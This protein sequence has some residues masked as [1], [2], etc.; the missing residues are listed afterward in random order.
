[1]IKNIFKKLL[2]FL[3]KIVVSIK[4]NSMLKRNKNQEAIFL[5]GSPLHGNIGD[6]AISIAERKLL[7]QIKNKQVLEIPGE[8]YRLCQHKIKQKVIKK[9]TILISG[10][11][12]LGSLWL[13]EENMVRSVIQTFPNN[14]IIILPQTMYFA[15]NEAGKKELAVSKQIYESHSNLWLFVRENNSYEFCK[16]NMPHL[17]HLYCVPDMVTYLDEQYPKMQREGILCC[18]RTDKEKNISEEQTKQLLSQLAKFKQPIK[19]TTTVLSKRINLKKRKLI[20]EEKLTEFRKSKMVVTDRLHAMLFAAITATPCIA[21]NNLSG[22]VQGVY[23][24]LTVLPYI[25]LFTSQNEFE[26]MASKLLQ[27]QHNEYPV[28]Y[29]QEKFQKIIEL[30]NQ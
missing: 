25:Q 21:V 16:K 6:H 18:F 11:G 13:N 9:D 28:E 4:L 27:K 2:Y 17:K 5:I 14:R 1:M 7:A 30:L 19:Q 29:F 10:G 22:K 12:F 3:K 20:F 26:Q 23:E 8:Y 15:E 24:W